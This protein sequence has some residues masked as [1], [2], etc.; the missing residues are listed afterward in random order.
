MFVRHIVGVRLKKSGVNNAIA[1]QGGF[2]FNAVFVF[3][4]HIL[5]QKAPVRDGVISYTAF[6]DAVLPRRAV[7]PAACPP[8][9]DP[10][11][12]SEQR[13]IKRSAQFEKLPRIIFFIDALL[14]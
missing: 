13:R 5:F 8:V 14:P 1:K 12:F 6:N 3:L 7:P 11:L 4:R 9:P 2:C 10:R